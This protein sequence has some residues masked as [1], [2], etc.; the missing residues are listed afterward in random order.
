MIYSCHRRNVFFALVFGGY[1]LQDETESVLPE[2]GHGF[3]SGF[4]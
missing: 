1:D 3:E 4:F 2:L